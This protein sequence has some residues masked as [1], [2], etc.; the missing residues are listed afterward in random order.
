MKKLDEL[1]LKELEMISGC[2]IPGDAWRYSID[3][4]KKKKLEVELFITQ[5]GAK[6][7]ATIE[8]ELNEEE[9]RN[10]ASGI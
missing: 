8:H 3:L 6:A 5:G 9:S 2:G 7:S 4:I 1:N 10:G